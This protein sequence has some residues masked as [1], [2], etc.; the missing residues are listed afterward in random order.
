MATKYH[1][2]PKMRA[3]GKARIDITRRAKDERDWQD[4]W[5]EQLYFYP[6]EFAD[7]W[8]TC[9]E[10]KVDDFAAEVGFFMDF[11]GFPSSAFSPSYAQFTSPDGDFYIGVSARE[12][13]EECTPPDTIRLQF[14]IID[15]FDTI[16]ELE[17]RG[18]VFEGKPQPVYD[19]SDVLV[20]TFRTPHGICIDLWGIDEIASSVLEDYDTENPV[21]DDLEGEL[22]EE[23]DDNEIDDMLDEL[24]HQSDD[25]DTEDENEIEANVPEKSNHSYKLDREVDDS[26]EAENFSRVT[27]RN[28]FPHSFEKYTLNRTG[29]KSIGLEEQSDND[30]NSD[31]IVSNS[32]SQYPDEEDNEI[33]YQEIDE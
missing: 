20:T 2:N 31:R 16:S 15:L 1:V 11:L 33:T 30:D 32:S 12:E 23:M 17:S 10:Y 14:N 27:D 8:K 9:F 13:G 25:T 24:L 28:R 22:D 19:D 26:P 3:Y 6:F 4:N 5:R 29:T 7:G 21:Y 18:I